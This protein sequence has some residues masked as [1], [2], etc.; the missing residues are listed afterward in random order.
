M[1]TS[2]THWECPVSA[3]RAKPTVSASGESFR[4]HTMIFLSATANKSKSIASANYKSGGSLIVFPRITD[5]R[6]GVTSRTTQS[7]PP[8]I[9]C[10]TRLEGVRVSWN[11]MSSS[12]PNTGTTIQSL[13]RQ[14]QGKQDTCGPSGGATEPLRDFSRHRSSD[15]QVSWDLVS[16]ACPLDKTAKENAMKHLC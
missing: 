4:F 12:V 13:V 15:L 11:L 16:S 2:W 8:E 6:K 3:R 5:G 7:R 14:V 9:S 10:G 1:T